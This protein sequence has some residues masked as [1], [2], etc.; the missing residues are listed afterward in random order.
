M[1]DEHEKRHNLW[2]KRDDDFIRQFD[3]GTLKQVERFM[4]EFNDYLETQIIKTGG[5]TDEN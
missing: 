5:N 4:K 3:P 1:Y 2:L